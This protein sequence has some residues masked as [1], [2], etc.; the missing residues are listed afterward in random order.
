MKKGDCI[1]LKDK[2]QKFGLILHHSITENE[3]EKF[4]FLIIGQSFDEIPSKKEIKANGI[5]GYKY[6]DDKTDL[7][8]SMMRTSQ[9]SDKSVFYT[10]VKYD[11][12]SVDKEV[13]NGKEI[14]II[15]N[16]KLNPEFYPMP[17]FHSRQNEYDEICKLIKNR[18]EKRGKETTHQ[19]T[20]YDS[21]PIEEIL[22]KKEA[23][24]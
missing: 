10:G 17:N 1:I 3:N 9:K 16:L 6:L 18:I 22:N 20:I 13:F 2:D 4:G 24:S 7:I 5:L 8:N 11:L 21:H 12:I 19:N 15:A 14:K 23:S